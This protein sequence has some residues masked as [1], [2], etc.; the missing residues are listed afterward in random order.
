MALTGLRQGREYLKETQRKG[1]WTPFIYWKDKQTKTIT[2][3]SSADEVAQVLMHTYVKIPADNEAGFIPEN[4]M[5]RKDPAWAEE[6]GNYCQLCD[7]IGHKPTVRHVAVGVELEPVG[8]EKSKQFRV[9]TVKRDREDGTTVEYPKWGLIV[10]A[11]NNFFNYFST[12][13]EREGD[14]VGHVFDVARKGN[15]TKTAYPVFPIANAEIQ[16]LEDVEAPSVL[17]IMN[18]MGSQEK[19]DR[20]LGSVEAGSQDQFE[21]SFAPEEAST[22]GNEQA[23]TKF[24]Q[25]RNALQDDKKQNGASRY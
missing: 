14:I 6:S 10:Q 4:F 20:L 19:Y 23:R 21:E 24:E 11:Y 17:E 16:G 15:D 1:R 25:L 22:E 8:G 18:D 5:C 3:L 13:A 2:F 7:E 9:V 12:F